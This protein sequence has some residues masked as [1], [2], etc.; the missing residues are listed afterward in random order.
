V[1][2]LAKS[3]V[4]RFLLLASASSGLSLAAVRDLPSPVDSPVLSGWVLADLNGD[5]N[6]DVATALPGR[7]D[8][9]GYTQEVRITLG[10]FQ[11]TSFHF[12]S[13]GATVELSSVDVDGDHDGDLVVFEPLSSQPIGVWIND[14][15]GSFH[16]GRLADFRKLWSE[17]PG[18]AWRASFERLALQAI[19]E[20]RTQSITP[21]A[22]IAAPEPIVASPIWQNESAR[23]DARRSDFRPRA[24]PRN[25]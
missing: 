25:F 24:P 12:Q 7:H 22:A 10:A 1:H 21:P 17:Q 11:Q 3:W 4:P 19:S 9:N 2:F 5:Q 23:Q 15:A 16:E 18:P 20:D 14:G 13:R 6:V 8:A